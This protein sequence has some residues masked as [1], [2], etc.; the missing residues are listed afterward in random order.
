M[1]ITHNNGI[2]SGIIGTP[3]RIELINQHS[4][5]K[6]QLINEMII[7]INRLRIAG[8]QDLPADFS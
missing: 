2:N 6:T 7:S 5:G 8:T 1:H 4:D 3:N